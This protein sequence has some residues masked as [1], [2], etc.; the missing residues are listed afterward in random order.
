[1]EHALRQEVG[2]FDYS[3][4]TSDSIDIENDEFSKI[5]SKINK[6]TKLA[7]N[8]IGPYQRNQTYC[9]NAIELLK[10]IPTNSIPMVLTDIP[11]GVINRESSGIRSFDKKDADIVDFSIQQLINEITRVC[12]GSIYIFCSSEQISEL[13]SGLANKKLTTRLCIWEK[14]NPSPVNCQYMWMSGIETCV[15]AR[16][17]GST[18]NEHYKN[19]VWRFPNGRSKRH[20]TEKPLKLFEYL[21][22]ASSKP[23]DLIL[24]P[25]MGSGTTAEACLKNKRDFVGFDISK[26]Y[27]NIA[28]E[29]VKNYIK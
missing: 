10:K 22:N 11:Y 3:P 1:M 23:G 18:F 17:S 6:E 28:N 16:K 26:E 12:S 21:V 7:L 29:R 14:T 20:P 13:R 5:L 4:S 27:V 15:Y 8:K 25:F 2:Y 9:G 19:S 24:D